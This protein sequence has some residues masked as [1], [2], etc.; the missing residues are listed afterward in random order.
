MSNNEPRI[1]RPGIVAPDRAGRRLTLLE[2]NKQL[3]RNNQE[4]IQI[5]RRQAES[6]KAMNKVFTDIAE[7]IGTPIPTTAQEGVDALGKLIERIIQL[8]EIEK[9][10]LAT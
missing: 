4:L 10:T 7:T 9:K 2:A 5:N 1:I 6:I 8:V 3:L